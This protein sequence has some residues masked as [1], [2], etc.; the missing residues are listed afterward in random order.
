[1]SEPDDLLHDPIFG[2]RVGVHRRTASLPEVL[3][4]LSADEPV[5]PTAL[6]PHQHHAWHA[7]LV[8]LAAQASHHA[9][10]RGL[11]TDSAPWRAALLGLSAGER[12]AWRLVVED[13]SKPGFQQ[14]PIPEGQL[15]RKRWSELVT[16]DALDILVTAKNHDIKQ[17][18]IRA[19]RAEHWVYA[20][21][22]LQ[23]MQG[24]LGAGNYGV[25]R[26]NGGFGNRSALAAAPSLRWNDRFKH[27]VGVWLEQRPNLIES[28]GYR[29]QDGVGLV[30]LKAWNGLDALP[31]LG[32][33]PFFIETCRRVRFTRGASGPTAWM[34]PTKTARLSFPVA[35]GNTGDIWT[36]IDTKRGVALSLAG[37]GF[38][39]SKLADLLFSGDWSKP[40]ALVGDE[41][42]ATQLHAWAMVRGQ[43]KTEGLHEATLTL[44]PKAR[45]MLFAASKS[46]D[47]SEKLAQRSK[48]RVNLADTV[49][50]RVFR[51][52]L[53]VLAQ[54]GPD[55]DIDF[56]DKRVDSLVARFDADIDAAFF[57][58]LL[59]SIESPA[60]GDPDGLR[61]WR[62]L[63]W[64]TAKR[65]FEA[66]L[67]AL[68]YP[69]ERRWRAIARGRA[70][71]FGA[72]HKH[73]PDVFEK[74][75]T[76]D[77]DPGE[78]DV[79]QPTP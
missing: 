66:S 8:Q 55:G 50:L 28:H 52:A 43:G 4:L 30:W 44:G 48:D 17:T 34:L 40:P 15:D 6:Q 33:D 19:P 54:G 10:L 76:S 38:H 26:M 69:S 59:G 37:A 9:Q 79:E 24:F 25:A 68:P 36:P 72:A 11:P 46:P 45:K 58:H 7:F 21:V 78:T 64:G 57:Q 63:L 61:A 29:D 67:D 47:A 70:M 60:Q 3:A 31:S 12:E 51:A 18:R 35:G 41:H 71:L 16:P 39:Y 2:L 20:L 32:L 22:N 75:P 49:R 1:M 13:V 23:T 74:Q 56:Q 73:L 65:H 5:E 77:Q 27:D 53:L 62:S 42:A 14:P